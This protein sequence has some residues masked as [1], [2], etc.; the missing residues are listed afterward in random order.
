MT[1]PALPG[2]R[3][4]ALALLGGLAGCA[5]PPR[6]QP[7]DLPTDPLLGLITTDPGRSAIFHSSYVFADPSRLAGQPAEAARS[8][9]EVEFLAVNLDADLRWIEMSP[10]PKLAL[11][12]ARPEWRAAVGI[13]ADADVQALIY[14][15]L[16]ARSGLG[17]R[18]L[19]A[20]EGALAAPNFVPGG[21]ANLQRLANLPPLPRTAQA[22]SMVL[23]GLRSMDQRGG[24][25]WRTY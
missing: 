12:Q 25:P 6:Q 23:Q 11:Q 7:V 1:H 22:T 24:S 10:A 18:N 16:T 4:V 3:P 15:L 19:A 8:I 17:A 9:A 5:L 13:P 2:R 21:A 14:A 20:A